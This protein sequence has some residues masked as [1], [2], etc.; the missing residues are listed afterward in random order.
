MPNTKQAK[1]RLVLDEK[2][3]VTNK[4]VRSSMRTAIK[5]VLRA[6]SRSEGEALL[7]MVQKRIDKAAKINVI[8]DNA[9][10]RYKSRLA[11]RVAQLG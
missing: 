10:A 4:V 9:A 3:R 8:H 11:H 7:P 5:K 2:R 1:K 6:E